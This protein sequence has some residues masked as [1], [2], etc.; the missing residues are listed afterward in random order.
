MQ[1]DELYSV[2]EAAKRLGGV[3]PATVANWFSRGRLVR[4]KVGRRTMVSEAEL[5]RFLAVS[6]SA[7][8]EI[9]TRLNKPVW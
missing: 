2:N 9:G 4:T 7:A 1:T 5:Q 6:G 3:S 8:T